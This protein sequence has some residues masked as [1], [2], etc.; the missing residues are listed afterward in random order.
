LSEAH[1]RIEGRYRKFAIAL[2]RRVLLALLQD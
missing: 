2:A 1:V